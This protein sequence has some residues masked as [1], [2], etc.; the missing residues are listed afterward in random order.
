[1]LFS[2]H[3]PYLAFPDVREGWEAMESGSILAAFGCSLI[4]ST[5]LSLEAEVVLLL[6]SNQTKLIG[7]RAV[8]CMPVN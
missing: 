4:S 2:L 8:P 6:F 1:M 3:A 7:S 5:E